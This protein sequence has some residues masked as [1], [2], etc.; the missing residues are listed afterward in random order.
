MFDHLRAD[1]L[2]D[3][4]DWSLLTL[5]DGNKIFREQNVSSVYQKLL[6]I[7]TAVLEFKGYLKTRGNKRSGVPSVNA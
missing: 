5:E 3:Q 6:K 4:V 2:E 1:F 7:S